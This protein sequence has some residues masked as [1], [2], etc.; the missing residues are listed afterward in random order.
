VYWPLVQ[1]LKR[2][3]AVDAIRELSKSQWKSQDE[4]LNKQW[5]LVRLT[6][7]KAIREVPYYRQVFSSIGWNFNNSEFSYEDFLKMPKLEK[8]ILRDHLPELLN[9]KYKGR[10]TKGMTSGS[11]GQS[12]S[13]YYTNE[14]E[15][16]SEAARWRGKEWWGIKPGTPHVS[17]WGRPYSGCKDRLRQKL[18]SYLMNNLLFSAFDLTEEALENIW[19][20]IYKFRPTIIYG[21][22]SAIYPLAVY[23]KESKKPVDRLG[24]KVIMTTAESITFQ[25]RLL[26]E[27]VFKCKTANEYGCSETGG[28]VYECPAGS[29]HI[30][31][32]L[33]FIE[34]LDHDGKPVPPGV[35]G[36]IF[37][38]HL[39][40]NY[41]PL[42][43]Y[44]V[45]DMGA[46]LAETCQ[47]G[48]GL[49][50]MKIS[51]AKQSDQIKL[52][53]GKCYSSEIFDYINLAVLDKFPA[54]ILQFRVIQKD[55]D[56]FDIEIVPGNSGV[57]KAETLFEN[58]IKEQL[59]DKIHIDITRTPEIKREGSGK[60][61]YFISQV[62]SNHSM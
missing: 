55:Y 36:E 53:G 49:P 17:L 57:E 60:L 3:H 59:G 6:V 45:G 46:Y 20:Q 21:Y 29:W 48:R 4:L 38:T 47:C 61:R 54:S 50:L 30:C 34:F 5:Q 9:P 13:L 19:K 2:E 7:N 31:S 25:Q 18:K 33:T 23:L 62:N 35:T 10:V 37:L 56:V 11:T 52:S 8:D 14:H 27:N 1:K 40:N 41:M 39:R 16:Y 24:L 22:P 15:S 58:L 12:L 51:V 42:I 28:F 44:R 43:R 32:E 26:I